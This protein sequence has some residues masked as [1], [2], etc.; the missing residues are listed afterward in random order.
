VSLPTPPRRKHQQEN[1][2]GLIKEPQLTL[3]RW[4]LVFR[5]ADGSL[6]YYCLPFIQNGI[7]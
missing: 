3:H 7:L 5:D 2:R 4:R 1:L 6:Y